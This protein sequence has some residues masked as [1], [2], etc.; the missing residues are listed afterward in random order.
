MQNTVPNR[1]L[2][3]FDKIGNIILTNS[4]KRIFSQNGTTKEES[5][6]NIIRADTMYVDILIYLLLMN[7]NILKKYIMNI[8]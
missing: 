2:K 3:G 5:G 6:C 7:D 1:I 4:F 8:T